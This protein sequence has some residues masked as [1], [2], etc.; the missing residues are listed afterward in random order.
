[1]CVALPNFRL[2]RKR[3]VSGD[4]PATMCCCCLRSRWSCISSPSSAWNRRRC[5]SICSRLRI[6][7][8]VLIESSPLEFVQASNG[9][10]DAGDCT[11]DALKLRNLDTELLFAS[12]SERVITGPAVA[13]SDTPFPND[14]TLQQHAL[15]RRIE[16]AFLHLKNIV[17]GALNIVGNLISVEL[18]ADSE[19]L[20][21]Q[22]IESAGG[23]FIAAIVHVRIPI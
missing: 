15:Q 7:P 2:A 11:H 13:S 16:R 17:G 9:L 6:S 20:E 3:A 12:G 1:M 14:P 18:A 5:R 22:Q 10:N 19:A 21:D 23:D 4:N 8:G